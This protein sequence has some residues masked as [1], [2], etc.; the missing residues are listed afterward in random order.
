MEMSTKSDEVLR[1]FDEEES[2]SGRRAGL[3]GKETPLEYHVMRL[4]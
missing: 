3:G 1:L 4:D 2:Q